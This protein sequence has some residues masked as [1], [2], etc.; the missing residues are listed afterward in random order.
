VWAVDDLYIIF[1]QV[2]SY[3]GDA[4]ENLNNYVIDNNNYFPYLRI[5]G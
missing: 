1:G 3:K 4:T 5:N 2:I